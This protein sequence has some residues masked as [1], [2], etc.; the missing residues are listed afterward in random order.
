LPWECKDYELTEFFKDV[1]P[2]TSVEL[3]LNASGRAS[4]NAYVKFATRAELDAALAMDGAYW[5]GTERWLKI[6]E[7]FDRAPKGSFGGG[8]G[9]REGDF[10]KPEVC[11]SVFVGNLPSDVTED[12]VIENF[13][14]CGEVASVRLAFNPNDGSFKGFCHV[15]FRDSAH[16]DAAVKLAG[17][18]I[19]GRAIRC[20]YAPRN[21]R[22]GGRSGGRSGGRNGGFSHFGGR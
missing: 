20:D 11:D 17:T 5:P 7:G 21:G 8:G 1:G 19:G 18:D 9:S 16:C 13:S 12:Q 4:G 22:G 10:S 3:P 14:G 2:T 15:Q 6:L